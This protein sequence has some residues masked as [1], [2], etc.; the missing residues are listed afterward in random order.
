MNKLIAVVGASGVGK[1]ALV[2]ALAK[3]HPF[4]TAY[5]QHA[6]RP[7]QTLFKNDAH[8]ALANQIDYLLLRAEQEK[9]LRRTSARIGLIDGGLDLDF[10]GFTRLFH[11]RGLLTGPEFD[12]CESVYNFLREVCP[13]PELIVHLHAD[14]RTVAGRLSG[15]DRIN[16]ARAEDTALFNSFLDEWLADIPSEDLLQLDVSNEDI[17]YSKSVNIILG[18]L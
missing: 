11:S 13:R 15:R 16:I 9:Y 3:T 8:Y 18:R 6:E 12:L 17:D 14:E 1:T 4:A 7:F 10:H 2:Q 5:E